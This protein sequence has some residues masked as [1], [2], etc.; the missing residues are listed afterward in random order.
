MFGRSTT[1]SNRSSILQGQGCSRH[2]IAKHTDECA[3]DHGRRPP[4][5]HRRIFAEGHVAEIGKRDEETASTMGVTPIDCNQFQ[6]STT[7][8]STSDMPR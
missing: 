6:V 8:C 7:G 5:S 4:R 2:E 1:E 3:G